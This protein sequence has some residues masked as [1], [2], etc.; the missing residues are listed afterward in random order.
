MISEEEYQ[1]LMRAAQEGKLRTIKVKVSARETSAAEKI[2]L[3][4]KQLQDMEKQIKN[5]QF[6]KVCLEEEN[7]E[8]S[9]DADNWRQLRETLMKD[10]GI[11]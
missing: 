2:K 8:L 7:E 9:R 5:L 6:E 4:E 10:M 1:T 3:L 11:I